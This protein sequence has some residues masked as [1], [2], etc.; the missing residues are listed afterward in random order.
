MIEKSKLSKEQLLIIITIFV[1]VLIL[2]GI[3][4]AFFTMN[5]SNGSTA[6]ITNTSGKMTITYADGN[7]SLLVSTNITPSDKIIADKTFTLTG[8]NTTTAG[9]G[10][11]MPYTVGLGYNSSFS[12]GM[13]HYYIRRIDSN[14][15]ITSDFTGA[16]DATLPGST[17]ST[18]YYTGTLIKG[19]NAYTEMVTGNF[20]PNANSQVVTF[21][22]KLVFPDNGQ[23]QDSEKGKTLNAEIVINKE[24]QNILAP[25]IATL[26]SSKS[27][28]AN[29][30]TEDGLIKDGTGSINVKYLSNNNQKYN[31]KMLNQATDNL[32]ADTEYDMYDNLRYVGDNPNNYIIFN[33]ELWRIIGLFNNVTTIDDNGNEKIE[34]VVK[35]IRGSSIGKYKWNTSNS[36]TER[37]SEDSSGDTCVVNNWATSSLSKVLNDYYLNDISDESKQYVA[38]VKWHTGTVDRSAYLNDD[39]SVNDLYNLEKEDAY[40]TGDGCQRSSTWVGKIG[41]IDI[42]DYAFSKIDTLNESLTSI[43]DKF[44]YRWMYSSFLGHRAIWTITSDRSKKTGVVAI[45]NLLTNYFYT[46]VSIYNELDT[47]PSLYLKADTLSLAGNGTAENP[48]IISH[49]NSFDTDSWDTIAQNV[50]AGNSSIYK[51]GDTKEVAIDGKSYTVRVA[52]NSTPSECND[53]NFSQTAC[54]FVV[55]FVD[56]V[57]NRPMNN[58]DTNVGGW[59]ASKMRTYINGEFLSMMPNDLQKVIIDTKV[60]SGHGSSDTSNFTSVDKIYLLSFKEVYLDGEQNIVSPYDTAYENT[61]QLDYYAEHNVVTGY[62]NISTAQKTSYLYSDGNWWLRSSN[63]SDSYDFGC[64]KFEGYNTFIS[65]GNYDTIAPAFR[66]G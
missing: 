50:K 46:F 61:R 63:S 47:Y 10:L 16:S 9:A 54:G 4:Y 11:N 18:K 26:Y 57:G 8:L 42:S 28:D 2:S 20:K 12:D 44:E 17:D 38:N 37:T 29:G 30:I 6:L 53:A 55:E 3:T 31:V 49:K 59:P 64:V 23:N 32:I 40:Y 41:L 39:I 7:S 35:I 48:Y 60:I 36:E 51:V 56:I 24:E 34:Q 14:A 65:S 5:N 27:K 22:L 52:N 19:E 15:N 43:R 1:T 58:T 25:K 33:G 66:I 21:N 45:D 13:I 62:Q